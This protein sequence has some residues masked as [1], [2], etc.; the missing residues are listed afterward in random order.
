MMEDMVHP[1]AN[2][3]VFTSAWERIVPWTVD[4]TRLAA[5]TVYYCSVG[6]EPS[7]EEAW[8]SVVLLTLPSSTLDGALQLSSSDSISGFTNVNIHG[9]NL[10]LSLF[11]GSFWIFT[12]EALGAL[13]TTLFISLEPLA[14]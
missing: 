1:S 9:I 5:P 7:L 13:I 14:T 10:A 3:S 6:A 4:S 2:M 11:Y 8:D 12:A